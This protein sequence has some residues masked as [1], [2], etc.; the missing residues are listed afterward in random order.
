METL[1]W[2]A[3][4]LGLFSLHAVFVGRVPDIPADLRDLFVAGVTGDVAG[5][6]EVLHRT[7][8]GKFYLFPQTTGNTPVG[9]PTPPT[10]NPTLPKSL[11]LVTAAVNLGSL[12]RGYRLGGTG[13]DFYDC[14]GLMWRAAQVAYHF[15]GT[16]FTTFTVQLAKGFVRVTDPTV[17]DM[18]VWATHHMG[19][20]TS[21]D[22]FY[23]ARSV[24]SGI[25]YSSISATTKEFGYSPVYY[26]W[27]GT[28]PLPAV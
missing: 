20:V 7:S 23:A 19:V 24:A 22:Q 10:P 12:A 21:A 4:L 26:R 27:V 3:I 25:G 6:T 5:V 28:S 15:T 16:R 2:S 11:G 9:G 13:P 17:N 1:A 18:V 8:A 14:S